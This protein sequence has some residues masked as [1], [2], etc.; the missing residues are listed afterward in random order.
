MPG[1]FMKNGSYQLDIIEMK[2]SSIGR[3]HELFEAKNKIE[4]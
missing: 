3:F 2:S 1:F 4:K